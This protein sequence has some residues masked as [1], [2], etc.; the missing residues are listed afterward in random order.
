MIVPFIL[1]N[2]E[3]YFN[4]SRYSICILKRF[5]N[6]RNPWLDI[7]MAISCNAADVG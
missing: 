4:V 5:K 7:I 3:W 1:L 6:R 2:T